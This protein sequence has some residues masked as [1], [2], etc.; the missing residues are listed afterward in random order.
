MNAT[1]IVLLAYLCNQ[2]RE[3]LFVSSDNIIYINKC[4]SAATLEF[5]YDAQQECTNT[6]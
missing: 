1:F 5:V 6:T 4:H 3:R 2:H